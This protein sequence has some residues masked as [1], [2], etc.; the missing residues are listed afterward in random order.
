MHYKT[1]A[2]TGNLSP[3]SKFLDTMRIKDLEAKP[4]LS[5]TASLL[6]SGTQ[7]VVLNYV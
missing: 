1:E 6:P 5:I 3:V 7:T 2:F 4:K